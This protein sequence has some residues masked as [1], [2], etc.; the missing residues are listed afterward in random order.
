M[1]S[2]PVLSKQLLLL[3]L[4]VAAAASSVSSALAFAT[5]RRN[6][7]SFQAQIN[8]SRRQ[9]RN[10][11]SS[12]LFA[13]KLSNDD[14]S[15]SKVLVLG[16]SGF[17]GRHVTAALRDKNISFIATSTRRG[18]DT[19]ELD[20]TSETA[21]QQVLELCI[22][23]EISTIVSTVGSIFKEYDYDVNA[24]SGRIAKAV[25]SSME[26]VRVNKFI[27]VGN[28]HRVRNVCKIVSSLQDYARGKEESERLIQESFRDDDNDN[29][30]SSKRR[31]YCIIRPTFIYGGD[32][33]GWNPPRLP[34]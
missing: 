33:F 2:Y 31:Q 17:V 14:S 1:S 23:Q 21:A 25:A 26:D 30:G 34:S 11:S 5:S 8:R 12:T 29:N 6:V 10:Q 4:L 22:S 16:G 19:I 24:A 18:E 27:F 13:S 32:E 7:S 20:L 28:S 3:A 9:Q 15:N